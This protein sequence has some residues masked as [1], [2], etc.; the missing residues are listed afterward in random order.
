[1]D[2]AALPSRA[3]LHAPG[4]S[5]GAGNRKATAVGWFSGADPPRRRGAGGQPRQAAHQPA[6]AQ[7]RRD[8]PDLSLASDPSVKTEWK[9]LA[10]EIH[11]LGIISN[12]TGVRSRPA[13]K[14]MRDGSRPSAS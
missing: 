11:G 6:R 2:P 1:M 3:T 5:R 4:S 13:A 9:G 10:H 14:P 7:A 8:H 12:S